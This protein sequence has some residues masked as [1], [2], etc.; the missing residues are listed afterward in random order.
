MIRHKSIMWRRLPKRNMDRPDGAGAMILRG[1]KNKQSR[2]PAEPRLRPPE[3]LP[4]SRDVS[5]ETP[6]C[7][8]VTCPR[9]LSGASGQRSLTR[10]G[11][12]GGS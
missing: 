5:A 6:G 4:R 9:S 11:Q 2:C 1:S 8:G 3:Y 7:L 10:Q 12:E